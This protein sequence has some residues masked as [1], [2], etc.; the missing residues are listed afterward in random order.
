MATRAMQTQN[1]KKKPIPQYVNDNILESMRGIGSS[2]GKTVTK[3]VVGQ[4]GL[5]MIQTLFQTPQ[6]RTEQ[7]PMAPEVQKTHQEQ[8]ARTPS[9]V[10]S[11]HMR[12][13]ED[14]RVVRQ[15]IEEVR[16]ELKL[17]VASLK[18]V[19]QEVDKAVS[20]APVDPGIY[21]L[22]FYEQLKNF[23]RII[24]QQVEDS[25]VWLQA[26][27]TRKK[28]MGYWGMYKKHGT[29]FGLSNERSLATSAG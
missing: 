2:V 21:H 3:D 10:E 14:A 24:R 13:T 26:F 1:T 8:P 7:A 20:E 12:E 11:M 28:K 6:T 27:Q 15:Q 29:T 19:H 22:N 18:K 5:D 23:L 9:F 4:I 16:Q 25:G 17:L